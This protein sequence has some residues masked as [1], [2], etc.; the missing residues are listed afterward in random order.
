MVLGADF[1]AR[2]FQSGIK[3]LEEHGTLMLLVF[4]KILILGKFSQE[5]Y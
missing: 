4:H 2:E 1:T 3:K 5:V